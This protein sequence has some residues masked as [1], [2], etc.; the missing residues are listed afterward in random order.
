MRTLAEIRLSDKDRKAVEAASRVLR[1]R[2]PVKRVILFGSK[3]RGTDD[4]VSDIDLLVL[5]SQ[6]LDWEEKDQI[7]GALYPIQLES[8]VL[9]NTLV[10]DEKEWEHGL[11][12]V[13]P[14][15]DEI[16]R[17]GIEV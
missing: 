2:F 14:I 13:L 15:K 6:A 7:F 11:H 16:D 1:E 10:V 9:F 8:R 17:D 12:Q 3:A 5:T 4:E